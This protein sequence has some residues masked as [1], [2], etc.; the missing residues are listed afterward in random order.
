MTG[1]LQPTRRGIIGGIGLLFAAP[2]IVRASSLMPVRVW[3]PYGVSPAA[4][5]VNETLTGE[6]LSAFSTETISRYLGFQVRV[7]SRDSA[8]EPYG[9]MARPHR[10]G[11][12]A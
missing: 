9:L 8:V 11:A 5:L 1:I 12:L 2:A 10:P 3:K 6:F 4:D 7:L